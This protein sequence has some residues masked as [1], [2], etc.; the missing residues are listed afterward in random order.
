[1]DDGSSGLGGRPL[2]PLCRRTLRMRRSGLLAA[3]SVLVS[4]I[5]QKDTT[6]VSRILHK[7]VK[8]GSRDAIA[9]E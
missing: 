9:L 1:M 6:L 4:R 2:V 5:L 7:N 8:S 3:D